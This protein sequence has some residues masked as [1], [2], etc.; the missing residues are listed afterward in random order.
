MFGSEPFPISKEQT[1][2]GVRVTLAME[3]RSEPGD[4]DCL[5][6]SYAAHGQSAHSRCIAHDGVS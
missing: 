1:T 2:E 5:A 3:T 6:P 4:L